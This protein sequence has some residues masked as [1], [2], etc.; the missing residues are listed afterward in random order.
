[1]SG[2]FLL[3][4]RVC[5]GDHFG[6]LFNAVSSLSAIMRSLPLDKILALDGSADLPLGEARGGTIEVCRSRRFTLL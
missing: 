1:M 4:D 3:G 5:E 2:L 6:Y